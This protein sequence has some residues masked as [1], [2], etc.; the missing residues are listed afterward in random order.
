MIYYKE[1]DRPVASASSIKPHGNNPLLGS[2]P[3]TQEGMATKNV[4][5]E[6][7]PAPV[8]IL[9]RAIIFWSHVFGYRFF[10][11]GGAFLNK[12]SFL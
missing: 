4:R 11:R 8:A 10:V 1:E 12:G 3:P 2:V 9:V 7:T 6:V 5:L